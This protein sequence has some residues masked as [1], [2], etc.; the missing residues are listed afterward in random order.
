MNKIK[1]AVLGGTIATLI[2]T[3]AIAYASNGNSTNEN[4][5]SNSNNRQEM[6]QGAV[7]KG[8]ISE[9]QASNLQTYTQEYR[10]E[11]R[12]QMMEERLNSAVEN[13][14]I[15]ENEAQQIRDWQNAKP[16]AMEKLG[17]FGKGMMR[18][19]ME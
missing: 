4:S 12:Q 14:T 15:T 17:G 19:N 2:T 1:L 6:M 11:Q 16:A 8:I 9:E 5:T 3:G 13:G 7:E 10:Q 18:G